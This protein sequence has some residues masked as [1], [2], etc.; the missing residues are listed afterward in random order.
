M[1]GISAYPAVGHWHYV[2]YGL[3]E[4]WA[5]ESDDPEKSGFGFEFTMRVSRSES[6]RDPP[7]WP[8]TLLEKLAQ[9]VRRGSEFAVGHQADVG[10]PIDG[11]TIGRTS[12]MFVADPELA[13]IE[14]ANGRLGF[15]EVVG[16]QTG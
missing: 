16:I 11:K 13:T 15:L 10:E 14:T 9:A 5:K 7:G 1:Q 2:T 4:L 12:L 8:F 6:D 3:S